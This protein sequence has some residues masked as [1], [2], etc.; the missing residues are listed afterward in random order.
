[1]NASWLVRG[2]GAWTRKCSVVTR[3]RGL[4]GGDD[5]KPRYSAVRKSV[6]DAVPRYRISDAVSTHFAPVKAA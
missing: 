5:G 6:S 1:M 3:S 2:E 4:R